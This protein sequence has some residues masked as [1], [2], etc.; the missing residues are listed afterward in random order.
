VQV[1]ECWKTVAADRVGFLD[2]LIALLKESGLRYCV[3]GDQAVNAFVE[4]V[5]SLDLDLAVATEDVASAEALLRKHFRVERFPH[6]VNVSASG[7]DLRVQLQTRHGGRARGRRTSPTSRGCWRPSP[8]CGARCRTT[9]WRA[10][11]D[12][13]FPLRDP[14]LEPRLGADG[15]DGGRPVAVHPERPRADRRG[16][17]S[18]RPAPRP[19]TRTGQQPG[20]PRCRAAGT[21]RRDGH[22]HGRGRCAAPVVFSEGLRARRVPVSG[23]GVRS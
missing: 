21:A 14:A 11:S 3:I 19:G 4:P 15:R 6:S 9:S 18:P 23:P 8:T 5:V 22:R 10:S 16:E 2:R 13:R 12:S 7:S 1:L 17:T 20:R